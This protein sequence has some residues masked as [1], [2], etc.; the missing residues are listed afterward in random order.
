MS[1]IISLGSNIGEREKNL[2]TAIELLKRHFHFIKASTV[3][4]T[5]PVDYL[6]QP[7]FLNQ[8]IE[9]ELPKLG[10]FEVLAIT[11]NI[12]QAM[13]RVKHI[14]KGPRNIDIDILF[15]GMENVT[16]ENL[17]IPHHAWNKRPFNLEML[18]QLNF[19]QKIKDNFASCDSFESFF[20]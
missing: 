20:H 3:A 12:E 15:F 14:P 8:L 16:S 10:P 18:E 9:F 19:F 4:E 1:L 17:T 2:A 5:A 7:Y 6:D 13:G 11:Q